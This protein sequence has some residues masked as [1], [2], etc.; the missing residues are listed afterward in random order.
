MSSAIES[1]ATVDDQREGDQDVDTE[2]SAT[3]D[4]DDDDRAV[5]AIDL[6][7]IMPSTPSTSNNVTNPQISNVPGPVYQFNNCTVYF[8]QQK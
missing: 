2:A 6:Q 1:F 7:T 8:N 3:V 4:L 5:M